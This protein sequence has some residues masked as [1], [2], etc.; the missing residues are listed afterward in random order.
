MLMM[1]GFLR[2]KLHICNY[3]RNTGQRNSNRMVEGE[4]GILQHEACVD[5]SVADIV[6][7]PNNSSVVSEIMSIRYIDL[8][9]PN[10][11]TTLKLAPL[12]NTTAE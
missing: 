5:R 4:C 11:T 6:H 2:P 8:Y 3:L 1:T 10:K 9:P 12:P 7:S